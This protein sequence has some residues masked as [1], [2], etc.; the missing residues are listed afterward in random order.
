M[1]A[2]GLLI[3]F[4]FACNIE[5]DQACEDVKRAAAQKSL[6]NRNTGLRKDGRGQIGSLLGTHGQTPPAGAA[7]AAGPHESASAALS[8]EG[9]AGVERV[10][11]KGEDNGL[12]ADEPAME[13]SAAGSAVL[14]QKQTC[15]G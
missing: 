4:G 8:A 12:R 7:A 6:W 5:E 3:L 2:E 10:R 11:S 14:R 9:T 15:Y 13:R 1:L